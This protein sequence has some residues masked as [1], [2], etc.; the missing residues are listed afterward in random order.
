MALLKGGKRVKSAQVNY[1]HDPL[2]ASLGKVSI[3][4]LYVQDLT[5]SFM[6]V[7][8]TTFFMCTEN[9]M[10]TNKLSS[11]NHAIAY[12]REVVK[13]TTNAKPSC[14]DADVFVRDD[15]TELSLQEIKDQGLFIEI[16]YRANTQLF[17]GTLED[18]SYSVLSI[19]TEEPTTSEND[20]MAWSSQ[21]NEVDDLMGAI[22]G[23][24]VRA[25]TEV[26]PEVPEP[27]VD[28]SKTGG[29][30]T[31]APHRRKVLPGL[32]TPEEYAKSLQS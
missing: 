11:A 19:T 13:R 27:R 9:G 30:G 20:I 7:A 10:K 16:S 23:K 24:I 18:G 26:G 22:S 8:G 12:L 17:V 28:D 6:F 15:G 21:P 1:F 14:V 2:P 5:K 29:S 3:V 31:L 32:R 25:A 4:H